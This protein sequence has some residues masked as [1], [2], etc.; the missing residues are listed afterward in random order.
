VLVTLFCE[1]NAKTWTETTTSLVAGTVV[2]L[3]FLL[4]CFVFVSSSVFSLFG[5][6]PSFGP[7]C[8]GNTCKWHVLPD[9]ST[10]FFELYEYWTSRMMSLYSFSAWLLYLWFSCMLGYY[11]FPLVYLYFF[12][13]SINACFHSGNFPAC[14]RLLRVPYDWCGSSFYALCFLSSCLEM[15]LYYCFFESFVLG[16]LPGAF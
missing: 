7:N 11:C 15:P 13:S 2:G 16:V 3:I 8:R 5:E 12:H 4:L 14:T 1:R 6:L 10:I 9:H